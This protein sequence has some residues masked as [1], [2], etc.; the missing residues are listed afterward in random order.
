M[1]NK[2]VLIILGVAVAVFALLIGYC[3]ISL[4]PV[5][6]KTDEVTFVI[7]PGTNKIDIIND[8]KKAEL[9]KNKY[10]A[11][12]YVFFSSKS[13]LQAGTYIID[14]SDSTLDIINQIA[15][16]KTKEVPATVRITFVEGL[17]F[18]DYAKLI[19]NNFDITYD[20]I[21]AKGEDKDYLRS[22]I[23]KY[24]FLD[25]SILNSKIYYPL[26]G[27]LSPNTYEFY[28][29]A[30]IETILEKLLSQTEMVLE[31]FKK[32][33]ESSEYSAHEILT[34]ASIIEKEAVTKSDR[35]TV[36]QVIY[37]RLDMGMTLG[38][39]VTSYYGVF[40]DM[41]EGLTIDDLNA[42]NPYNTRHKD[43]IGLPVGAICNPSLES[44]TASLNPSNTDYI[45]FFADVNTG[46]VYFAKTYEEFKA[47][48]YKFENE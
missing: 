28:Q 43:F 33:I 5:S 44:I 39:D 15:Q 11:L 7:K 21:V 47:I 42:K 10:V 45:Y 3:V 26:E 40:K 1:K 4:K 31:P 20:E 30:S 46:K 35:E 29:N 23:D 16:G 36:S 38:M 18:V 32:Q 24:W 25:S 9:I 34:M 12:A 13:N 37:T 17:R 48:E 27:Y 22:L 14:R 2:K 19:S 41:T 8:L 6:N